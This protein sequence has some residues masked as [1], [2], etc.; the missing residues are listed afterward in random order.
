MTQKIYTRLSSIRTMMG[1]IGWFLMVLNLTIGL[2]ALT[3]CLFSGKSVL[4]YE[5]IIMTV[6]IIAMIIGV[7][8]IV[9]MS[10]YK[11]LRNGN[12]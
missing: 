4:T 1:T 11:K 7:L 6:F 8:A 2:T 10:I 5:N 3:F 9:D 12:H